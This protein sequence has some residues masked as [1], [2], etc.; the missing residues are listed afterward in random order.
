M[1]LSPF[2]GLTGQDLSFFH[3]DK[4]DGLSDNTVTSVVS[5]ENGLIWI[6]TLNGLN[7]YDGYTVRNFFVRDFPG[8]QTDVISRLVCDHMNRIWIQGVDGSLSVLDEKREFRTITLVTGNE[9]IRV[10]YL[11]PV[12]GM[13]MFLSNGRLYSLEDESTLRFVPAIMDEEPFF[14]N[15]FERINLWD[16]DHL[17]FSGSDQLFLAYCIRIGC[18]LQKNHSCLSELAVPPYHK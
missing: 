5:D 14:K 11:L 3:L 8:L 7:S 18:N 13:P 1:L 16:E 2:R 6:G 15:K 17:V 4:S 10:D 9:P 12:I